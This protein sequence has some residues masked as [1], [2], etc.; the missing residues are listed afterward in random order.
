MVWPARFHTRAPAGGWT[1]APTAVMS[2]SRMTTVALGSTWPGAVTTRAPTRAWKPVPL[3]RS[4]VTGSVREVC[5][6]S[7][8]LAATSSP[9]P[10][11]RRDQFNAHSGR[12]VVAEEEQDGRGSD[13]VASAGEVE[14]SDALDQE[15]PVTRRACARNALGLTYNH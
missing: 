8:A 12:K 1:F 11:R 9:T 7:S 10:V 4:S 15:G 2:P 5:W 13:G 6:A 14:V 3:V